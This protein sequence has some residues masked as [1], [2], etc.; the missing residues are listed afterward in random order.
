[1][2]CWGANTLGQLGIGNTTSQGIPTAVTALPSGIVQLSLG[3]FHSCALRGDGAVFCWGDNEFGQL[4][5]GNKTNQS[6]PVAVPGITSAQQIAVLVNGT[7]ARLAGGAVECWGQDTFGAVG[8][9]TGM[10]AITSPV[11]VPGLP[12]SASIAGG[13]F[14]ACS[15]GIDASINCWGFNEAGEIGNGAVANA[16]TPTPLGL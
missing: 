16:W 8:D 11:Q 1:V 12:P 5:I 13:G 15:T 10:A 9:G 7:C 2:A 4:G 3:Q 14:N 6:S